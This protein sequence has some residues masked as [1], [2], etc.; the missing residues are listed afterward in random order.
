M[1]VPS[2]RIDVPVRGRGPFEGVV[3]SKALYTSEPAPMGV[4]DFGVT[5]SE[6]AYS[7]A[8]TAFLG[9]IEIDSLAAQGDSGSTAIT[10]QLNVV[11]ALESSGRTAAY[12]IQ[13]VPFLNTTS[14]QV[15]FGNNIWNFSSPSASLV[16]GALSGNGSI[17]DSGSG[18]YY[19][20]DPSSSSGYPGDH[21]TLAYSAVI[22]LEVVSSV[23]LGVPH[24]SFAYSDGYGWVTYD[25]V[26]FPWARGWADSGFV[27]DGSSSDPTGNFYDAELIYGGPGNGA[28]TTNLASNLTFRLF[29]FNGHNFEAIPSAWNF[30][31]DTAETVSNVVESAAPADGSGT[32]GAVL[33]AG[34]GSLGTLYG[35]SNVAVVD[36]TTSVPN[37]TLLV[38]GDP[39][40]Y[41]GTDVELTL[42]PG[43]YDLLLENGSTV[44]GARN[45]TL[46]AGEVLSVAFPGLS[47]S[48]PSGRGGSSVT[49]YGSLFARDATA[50]VR[51]A[52]SDTVL[53]TATTSSAGSFSCAFVVPVTASGPHPV[54]ASDS[55]D[56]ADSSSATYTETTDLM[57]AV[58][59]A[60]NGTDV[61]IALMISAN[62]SG[63]YAP[64]ST[65][66]WS[67]GD[68]G[69]ATTAT[70]STSHAYAGPGY[71]L[72]RVSV[73][74]SVGSSSTGSTWVT[75]AD[76]PRV[77]SLASNRSS[78]DVGQLVTFRA[79]ASS[80][81]QP[82]DSFS[83][84]GLPSSCTAINSSTPSCR[85]ASAGTL[86]L[87]ASVTDAVGVVSPASTRL[88]FPVYPDPQVSTPTASR[89]GGDLGESTTFTVAASLGSGRYT[90][91]WRGLPMGCTG[92][93]TSLTCT[94]SELGSFGISVEVV[95]SNGGSAISG[96]LVFLVQP[97]LSVNVAG[98]SGAQS[99]G[100][101]LSFSVVVAGGT[102][103]LSYA[104][105]F[106]DGST[107][108][109][110]TTNHTYAQSG[111]YLVRVWVNDSAGGSVLGQFNVTVNPSLGFLGLPLLDGYAVL[112]G[113]LAVV[114]LA[115]AAF[116]RRK[117]RGRTPPGV[118]KGPAEAQTDESVGEP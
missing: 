90:Y 82:Y 79:T 42:D 10:F 37:G 29:R 9:T 96:V 102:R 30:G 44:A 64:Y 68:G 109:G 12:W 45:V 51:W 112:G 61:G 54:T 27:V 117:R 65:Y 70:N 39:T 66:N 7:Y 41:R 15:S 43:A 98:P 104:W 76:P 99:A 48:P 34:P 55:A 89:T 6:T 63:G 101:R 84:N 113:I 5:P 88:S 71:Y 52:D 1:A 18:A 62:I 86:N 73:T 116:I 77:S 75:I 81:T 100:Q 31:S 80:G 74:D 57:V 95:D 78:G 83:W 2:A 85:L 91:S 115:A 105:A 28:T 94:P 26:S 11:L 47:L 24:V 4:A 97:A 22:S 16:S 60:A 25:N 14:D 23:V 17:F 103:P 3:D 19:A 38:N 106:G 53:C 92:S 118:A 69:M 36:V 58:T 59:P 111:T 32:P 35:P 49:A 50:T 13:D 8:S 108:S 21:V 110:P 33:K 46:T 40:A 20:D 114:A 56:P 93:K 107:G 87:T 67:F 72:L